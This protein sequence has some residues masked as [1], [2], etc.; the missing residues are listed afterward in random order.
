M[1]KVKDARLVQSAIKLDEMRAQQGELAAE[2][3]GLREQKQAAW[4]EIGRTTSDKQA[5]ELL[6][7][8]QVA[9]ARIA[10]R[11]AELDDLGGRIQVAI[12]SQQAIKREAHKNEIRQTRTALKAEVGSMWADMESAR[13][14][15]RTIRSIKNELHHLGYDIGMGDVLPSYLSRV[16]HRLEQG[17]HIKKH[18]RPVLESSNRSQADRTAE[19]LRSE[20]LAKKRAET[21]VNALTKEIESG[22]SDTGAIS[23]ARLAVKRASTAIAE[24]SR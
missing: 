1:E 3:A 7:K 22:G 19:A 13:D 4:D 21:R 5:G 18:R 9:A 17:L 24:L 11:S 6:T 23:I 14:R 10:A 12:N 16:F 15:V 20:I 8:A 2:I